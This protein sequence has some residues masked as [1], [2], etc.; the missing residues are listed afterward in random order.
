VKAKREDPIFLATHTQ[1]K[2]Q[3]VFVHSNE[4]EYRRTHYPTIHER[5]ELQRDWAKEQLRQER[6]EAEKEAIKFRMDKTQDE[7]NGKES[8]EDEDKV[9]RD[10]EEQLQLLQEEDE[11]EVEDVKRKIT[12]KDYANQLLE[13]KEKKVLAQRRG[14]MFHKE[15]TRWERRKIAFKVSMGYVKKNKDYSEIFPW[16]LLGRRDAASNIQTLL[17]LGVTHILNVT[18]DLP[19][20]FTQYFVYEKIPVRDNLEADIGK[21]FDT[22]INFIDRVE[23]C[24]GRVGEFSLLSR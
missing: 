11:K 5:V 4:E 3:E 7:L 18:H 1:I 13:I 19:N 12:M 24:K 23:R 16:L 2:R 8:N 15:Y 20:L 6:F 22:I 10:I 9:L 14:D 17:K 21:Y